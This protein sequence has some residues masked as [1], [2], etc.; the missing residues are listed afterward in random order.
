MQLKFCGGKKSVIEEKKKQ[1][2]N[3]QKNM[4]GKKVKK[5]Y[6]HKLWKKK[7]QPD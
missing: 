7:A 2:K 4:V 3:T 6:N 1:K 5:I